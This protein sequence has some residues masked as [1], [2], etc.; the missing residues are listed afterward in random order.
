[1]TQEEKK[2]M[3]NT[4]TKLSAYEEFKKTKGLKSKVTK[5]I[6]ELE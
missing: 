1:M 5:V 2:A 3:A 6:E 4:F